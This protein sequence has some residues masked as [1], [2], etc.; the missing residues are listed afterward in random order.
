MKLKTGK[1]RKMRCR[2]EQP[3]QYELVIS[4]ELIPLNSFLNKSISLKFTGD[5][6]CIH[7]NR[8]TNKSFQQGYCFPCYREL[9]D[10][11]LCMIHPER[12]AFKGKCPTDNWVTEGH[13]KPHIIYLANSSG[14]KVGV[15]RETQVPTRWIDQG[16]IQALPIIK[17][18]N[19]YEAGCIEVE[20]KK[21][22]NDK[23]NWRKMLKGEVE[24]ID[25][26]KE[27]D[28]VFSLLDNK[29]LGF[30]DSNVVGIDYPVVTFPEKITSLSFDKT[31]E[32]AGQLLGIKGQYLIFDKGVINIR[33]FGGYNVKFNSD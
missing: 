7:C 19:R 25:L 23:T 28:K 10:S 14:L 12:C 5:I 9:L 17:T 2:L 13:C 3:V 27:R 6:H 20:L 11:Q 33:K 15:T 26:L 30:I 18:D 8:K 16:A 29:N 4:D 21:H 32:V 22:F 31:P 24:K 1:L